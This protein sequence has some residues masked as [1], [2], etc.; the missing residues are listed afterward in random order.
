V[1]LLQQSNRVSTSSWGGVGIVYNLI[2]NM[3]GLLKVKGENWE[4][5]RRRRKNWALGISKGRSK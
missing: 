1:S 3:K 5:S 2:V 4:L